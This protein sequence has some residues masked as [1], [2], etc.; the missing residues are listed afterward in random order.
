MTYNIND[1]PPEYEHQKCFRPASVRPCIA[2]DWQQ[3]MGWKLILDLVKDI[4]LGMFR[5]RC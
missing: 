4:A 3:Q 2:T 1:F 5:F